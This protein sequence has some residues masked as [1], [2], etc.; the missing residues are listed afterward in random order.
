MFNISKEAEYIEGSYCDKLGTQQENIK[1]LAIQKYSQLKSLIE[2]L[3]RKS[4]KER[5]EDS[6]IIGPTFSTMKFFVTLLLLWLLLIVFSTVK[7]RPMLDNRCIYY[8]HCSV[9]ETCP[10][11]LSCE[12]RPNRYYCVPKM[13]VLLNIQNGVFSLH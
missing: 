3:I 8:K 2:K 7:T 6:S 9:G 4:I 1:K 5:K 13:D 12:Y 11:D 10:C